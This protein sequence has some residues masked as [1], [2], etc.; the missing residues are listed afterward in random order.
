MDID[1]LN[2]ST[3]QHQQQVSLD[4]TFEKAVPDRRTTGADTSNLEVLTIAGH[5][6]LAAILVFKIARH[7]EDQN[8]DDKV[9]PS[10]RGYT[11]VQQALYTSS[12]TYEGF[13]NDLKDAA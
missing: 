1:D 12:L 7:G 13:L 8:N 2:K 6:E 4:N 11:R 5:H 3:T 10:T 9:T